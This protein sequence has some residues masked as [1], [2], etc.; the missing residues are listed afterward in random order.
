MRV[1]ITALQRFYAAPLGRVAVRMTERRLTGL[2]PHA[3]GLDVLGLG[4]PT[5]YLARFRAG[6]RRVAIAMPQAQGAHAWPAG[7]EGAVCLSEETRLPF[8]DSVFDRVLLVHMLEE[9]ENPR[10]LL[11]E[12]WRVTAP[13]GRILVVVA[14][15]AGLWARAEHTPFGHGRPYSRSQLARLLSEAM[16]QPAA[17]ARAVYLPP[18]GWLS[19]L[20]YPFERAGGL[21][22]PPFGGLLLMEAVKRLYAE[23]GEGVGQ[24]VPAPQP[25]RAT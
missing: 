16:F 14:N 20:A 5:P 19:R 18:V 2:W 22:W 24:R 1:D 21:L 12:I 23:P 17:R 10:T 13:E 7:G 6:A 3:D 11:R 15:R 9:T 25:A 4:Y 8:M